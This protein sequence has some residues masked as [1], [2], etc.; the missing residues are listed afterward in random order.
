M[1]SPR[2]STV[3]LLTLVA[4]ALGL[5]WLVSAPRLPLAEEVQHLDR[6]VL[7]GLRNDAAGTDPV[8]PVW[9]EEAMRDVTALGSGTVLTLATLAVAL[10]LA[11]ERR[12][13]D[14]LHALAALAGSVL[15]VELLKLGFG[16]PRPELVMHSMRVAGWS[17]PSGHSLMSTA[18]FLTLGGLLAGG[19]ARRSVR[20]YL[21]GLAVFL[22]VV[23]GVSR[24]YLGVH[25]PSDVVAG[26]L[27][28]TGWAGLCWRLRRTG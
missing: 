23:V 6:S 7:L 1:P 11:L 26:W 18:V 24:V 10:L 25:W 12:R 2:R 4:L 14:A 21:F 27:V 20:R 17:F 8:G 3:L 9:W 22:A 19:T 28:G 16:R 5:G 15:L 13:G